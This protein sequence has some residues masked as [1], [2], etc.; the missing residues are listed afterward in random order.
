MSG[1][2][3][4]FDKYGEFCVQRGVV[5][6]ADL[7]GEESSETEQGAESAYLISAQSTWL[8]SRMR[9]RVSVCRF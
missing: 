5:R 8:K 6:I 7:Q 3:V 1:V 9:L 2:V 4:G